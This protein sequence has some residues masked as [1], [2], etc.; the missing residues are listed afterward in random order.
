MAPPPF[1]GS[2]GSCSC[3][4]ILSLIGPSF[5]NARQ[6]TCSYLLSTTHTPW[7]QPARCRFQFLRPRCRH[8]PRVQ[9]QAWWLQPGVSSRGKPLKGPRGLH[10][11][12]LG[13]PETQGVELDWKL[14]STSHRRSHCWRP[15]QPAARPPTPPWPQLKQSR[16]LLTG[17]GEAAGSLSQG[18]SGSCLLFAVRDGRKRRDASVEVG[19]PR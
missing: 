10:R 2:R 9:T 18:T 3:S 4:S 15:R 17:E 19:E 14:S 13:R 5:S 16:A 11:E 8:H 7:D 12:D 6:R 1:L